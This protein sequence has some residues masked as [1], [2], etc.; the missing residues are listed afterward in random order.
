MIHVKNLTSGEILNKQT[1]SLTP[2]TNSGAITDTTT[3]IYQLDISHEK[4]KDKHGEYAIEIY[5]ASPQ[6]VRLIG[7]TSFLKDGQFIWTK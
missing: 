3:S 6:K 7:K 1:I 5:H 2:H 4:K